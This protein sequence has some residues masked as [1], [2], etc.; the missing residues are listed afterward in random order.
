MRRAII[1]TLR[2]ADGTNLLTEE[3]ESLYQQIRKVK[4]TA[5]KAGLKINIRKTKPIVF[6]NKNIDQ[7]AHIEGEAIDNVEKYEYLGSRIT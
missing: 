7:N 5:E 6:G 4:E 1:N 3:C 2:F